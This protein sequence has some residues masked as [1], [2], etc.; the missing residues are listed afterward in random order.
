[1]LGLKFT[2]LGAL[3]P[4]RRSLC[5]SAGTAGQNTLLM[6]CEWGAMGAIPRKKGFPVGMASSKK[7]RDL[8]VTRSVE[9]SPGYAFGGSPLR[10]MVTL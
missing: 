9:Y 6:V 8:S 1:M 7:P 5:R 4:G 2:V 10:C 3:S